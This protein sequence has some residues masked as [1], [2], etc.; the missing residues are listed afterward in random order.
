ML[1]VLWSGR[2]LPADSTLGVR[3]VRAHLQGGTSGVPKA[4]RSAMMGPVEGCALVAAWP[5]AGPVAVWPAGGGT[6]NL[7]RRVET[8][9]GDYFLRL[10]RNTRDPARVRYEHAVLLALQ[11]QGLSFRVPAPVPA[12]VPA[13]GGDTVVVAGDGALAALF[14]RLPGAPPDRSNP[15]HLRACGAALAEL[16]AALR[17]LD[18]GPPPP[19]GGTYGDLERVHPLVP[20][21]WALPAALP[22]GAG[23]RD[24]LAGVLGGL[25]AATPGLYATLPAQVCHNDYGPG[26]TLQV[27]G[28]TSAVLDF[29]VAAPDLR[30]IDVAAGW[31]FAVGP[32]WG[33]GRELSAARAFLAGYTE[34]APLTPAEAEAMPALAR[35]QRAAALVHWAGRHRA[36]LATAGRVREQ[37]RRLLDLDRWLDDHGPAVV[38]AVMGGRPARAGA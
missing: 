3:G 27:E 6:N 33:T 1:C 28:R 23:D 10:Y 36:G 11:G 5:L 13:A 26:N 19:G 38:A 35:L 7:T 25:R 12:A 31:Y 8:G 37:A 34:A 9:A 20:D 22:L 32:A 24:R 2:P 17:R 29:E 21:P 16:H 15:A 14:P 4:G 30:A 18:L